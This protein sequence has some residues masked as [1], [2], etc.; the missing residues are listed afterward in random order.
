M[1]DRRFR[2]VRFSLNGRS[3]EPTT[4]SA[5]KGNGECYIEILRE[6]KHSQAS[7]ESFSLQP[8]WAFRL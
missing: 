2:G 5:L 7:I 8:M 1:M 4:Y 3:H 6:E